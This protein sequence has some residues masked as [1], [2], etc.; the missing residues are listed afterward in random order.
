MRKTQRVSQKTNLLCR[1]KANVFEDFDLRLH[2]ACLT[3]KS[4]HSDR[5][6]DLEKLLKF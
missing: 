1:K 2:Y 3:T 5:L 4:Q 6:E